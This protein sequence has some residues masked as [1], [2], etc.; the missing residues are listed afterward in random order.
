M[1]IRELELRNFK[2]FGKSIRVPLRNDFITVTGPNGSGKSNIVDALLFAL[3]LSNSRAMRAERLPDL[4]FRGDN[5]KNPD[6]AEVTVWL[7]NTCRTIPLEQDVIEVSRK[8]RLRE[9]KYSSIYYFNGKTCSQGELQDRLSKAGI[10]PE[11]YNIVMQGDVTRIIEMSPSERRKII[12]EIAGVAE[13]DEKKK[14]A[15]E[16]LEIVRERIGRLDVIL[17]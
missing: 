11:G 3:C 2:S 13:F 5:G 8:V 9:D 15:M 1:F 4:I 14:K 7:D 6:F 16:E 17:E 10:M 12:D